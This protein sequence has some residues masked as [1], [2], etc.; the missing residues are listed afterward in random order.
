MQ[1]NVIYH[2]KKL[3]NKSYMIIFIDTEE[4]FWQNST[5]I[6]DKKKKKVGMEGTYLNIIE[7]TCSDSSTSF[8]IWIPFSFSSLIAVAT[9][10]KTVLNKSGESKHLCLPPDLRGNAFVFSSLRIM[11]SKRLLAYIVQHFHSIIF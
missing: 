2:I 9:T 11:F 4:T 6:H 5:P 10:S 1:L 8:P 7:V 3:K